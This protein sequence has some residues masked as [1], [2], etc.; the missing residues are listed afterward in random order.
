M[1]YFGL[2]DA[3]SVR[4]LFSS[5][6]TGS[7]RNNNNSMNFGNALTDY[8]NIRN[9]SY[10]KLMKAYYDKTGSSAVS[11]MVGNNTATSK[12]TTK[13]LTKMENSAEQL[14]ESADA[15]LTKGNKSV[16]RQES[17][18]DKNGVTTKEYNKDAIYEKVNAFVG[19]YNALV[20]AT[21]ETNTKNI[22]QTSTQMV[23]ATKS[24]RKMLGEMGITVNKDNTLSIDKETFLKADMNKVK[25]MFSGNGS[26]A[27]NVSTKA[28]MIDYYAQ[29]E[30]SKANTYGNKGSYN[31][32]YTNGG[33]Y[34]NYI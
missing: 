8:A 16:F 33:N 1:S 4:T 25:T 2:S 32:N 34:S 22:A 7:S 21:E 14:K 24:N 31:Y 5:F 11:D 20:E 17:I 23:N 18:T 28:S 12:D 13:Q 15:L 26:Y 6:N 10:H 27:Y 3:G 29:K 9:G 19:D 30:A